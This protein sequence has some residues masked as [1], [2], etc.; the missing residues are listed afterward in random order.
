LVREVEDKDDLQ[1]E[2]PQEALVR[3]LL[4]DALDPER[5]SLETFDLE[6]YFDFLLKS[7]GEKFNMSRI[8]LR[9]EDKLDKNKLKVLATFGLDKDRV[10]DLTF[11]TKEKRMAA[12]LATI[13]TCY[14]ASDLFDPD[15]QFDQI[16]F[17]VEL[18]LKSAF[19]C[20]IFLHDSF[21]GFIIYHKTEVDGF[22]P[23]ERELLET[24]NVVI[25]KIFIFAEKLSHSSDQFIRLS[26]DY[27]SALASLLISFHDA[28]NF[29]VTG[30]EM[31]EK[32]IYWA[33]RSQFTPDKNRRKTLDYLGFALGRNNLAKQLVLE[34]LK[35]EE[36]QF[37]MIPDLRKL[38]S[39]SIAPIQSQLHK[40]KINI[41]T[42]DIRPISVVGNSRQL[43]QVFFNIIYNSYRAIIE[44]FEERDSRAGGIIDIFIRHD[45]NRIYVDI[46]DN[47][48]G[49]HEDRLS[50]IF[51]QG[52][53]TWKRGAGT[54]IGLGLCK[55]IIGFHYGKISIDSKYLKGTTVR[56]ELPST[57]TI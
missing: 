16:R 31:I 34:T 11:V 39:D 45:P 30:S 46:T 47:G 36:R 55:K 33:E 49:I 19:A 50:D 2:V 23:I 43:R 13:R 12:Y 6:G 7:I 5:L 15:T 56:I 41:S 57:L 38:L 26:G 28:K 53:S 3:E 25:Q 27:S 42:D 17:A 32:A 9:H 24:L 8:I 37:S 35:G 4:L 20:P 29:L 22:T 51:I 40:I 54:G 44:A 18:N 21:V 52:K 10:K 1:K 48:I 14:Y